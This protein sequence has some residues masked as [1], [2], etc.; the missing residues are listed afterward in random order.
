M[1][2]GSSGAMRY[3]AKPCRPGQRL[4]GSVRG[5][6][7][8]DRVQGGDN[9]TRTQNTSMTGGRSWLHPLATART[10]W[11]AFSL[12][13]F[14]RL[15]A[16]I[17]S[18]AYWSSFTTWRSISMPSQTWT[19]TNVIA[20]RTT[21]TCARKRANAW[22]FTDFGGFFGLLELWHAPPATTAST[23]PVWSSA[24]SS[25]PS[26]GSI[27]MRRRKPCQRTRNRQ[28]FYRKRYVGSH[29]DI[30]PSNCY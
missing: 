13:F 28:W 11:T 21:Y 6:K 26:S 2:P 7:K 5:R 9:P 20:S 17:R 10:I 24:R 15:F 27:L 3:R 8:R 18:R 29:A 22:S 23:A 16:G 30:H 19:A 14:L 1:I 25:N 12:I 4:V